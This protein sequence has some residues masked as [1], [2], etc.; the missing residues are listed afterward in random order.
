MTTKT[1]CLFCLFLAAVVSLFLILTDHG[2]AQ[3]SGAAEAQVQIAMKN[4]MYHYSGPIA[5]HVV[6]LAG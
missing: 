3:S 2:F 5:V 1:L 4:V 6:Q